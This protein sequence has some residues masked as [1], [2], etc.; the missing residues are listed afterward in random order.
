MSA[1][2]FFFNFV[3]II[4]FQCFDRTVFLQQKRSSSLGLSLKILQQQ[5]GHARDYEE[6]IFIIAC[7]TIGNMR[8]R[9]FFFIGKRCLRKLNGASN[10]LKQLRC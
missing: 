1:S 8:K 5:T 2:Y 4:I 7:I 6:T 10:G 3:A 9:S